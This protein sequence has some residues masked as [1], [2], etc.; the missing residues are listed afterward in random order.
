LESKQEG[1]DTGLDEQGEK[2]ECHASFR[3]SVWKMSRKQRYRGALKQMKEERVAASLE[4]YNLA[5]LRQE[6]HGGLS[7][8]VLEVQ[9]IV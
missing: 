9:N 6:R 7:A 3:P 5:K 8:R 4:K 2:R 1:N